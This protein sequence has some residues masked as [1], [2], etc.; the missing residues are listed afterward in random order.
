MEIF[1][2]AIIAALVK[3]VAD[4]NNWVLAPTVCAYCPQGVRWTGKHWIHA[5]GSTWSR[6]GHTSAQHPAIPDRSFALEP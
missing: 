5:D 6:L 3:Q 4:R 1:F 2:L